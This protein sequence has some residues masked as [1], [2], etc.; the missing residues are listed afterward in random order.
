MPKTLLTMY[1]FSSYEI[2]DRLT[3][4]DLMKQLLILSEI[5]RSTR[6]MH[7]SGTTYLIVHAVT[8]NHEGKSWWGLEYV[9]IV[10]GEPMFEVKHTRTIKEFIDGRFSYIGGIFD[11][12][13]KTN[14]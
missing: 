7:K 11:G 8:I 6:V 5:Y 9:P 14:Q 10:D 1:P 13:P 3:N 2:E 12:L 4:E